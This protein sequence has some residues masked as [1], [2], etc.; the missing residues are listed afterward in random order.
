MQRNVVAVT[1]DDGLTDVVDL[2]VSRGFR[3]LPVVRGDKLVG[4]ISRRDLIRFTR[5]LQQDLTS[6]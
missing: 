2:F 5:N 4:I 1:E 6:C 3:R